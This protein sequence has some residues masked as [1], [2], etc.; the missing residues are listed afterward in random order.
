MN[1]NEERNWAMFAHLAALSGYVIPLGS[2]I[3]PLVVWLMKRDESTM[4]DMHGKQSLNFQISLLLWFLVCIPLAFII[5]GIFLAIALGIMGLVCVIINAIK[6]SK[7]EP[8]SYPLT[9]NFVK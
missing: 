2:I 6:A 1:P 7:G 8:T 5:I 9:I 4:V 3:G